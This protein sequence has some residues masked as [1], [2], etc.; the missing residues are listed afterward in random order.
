MEKAMPPMSQGLKL[1][2]IW[3]K[4]L[5]GKENYGKGSELVFQLMETV[6]NKWKF[7]DIAEKRRVTCLYEW[8][9]LVNGLSIDF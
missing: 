5:F 9:E 3:S 7:H 6:K 4:T 2:S 1:Q 8:D